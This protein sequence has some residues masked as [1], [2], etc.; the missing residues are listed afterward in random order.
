MP[1]KPSVI[2]IADGSLVNVSI[3]GLG[4]EIV[5]VGVVIVA[6]VR[7][8]ISLCCVVSRTPAAGEGDGNRDPARPRRWA[9]YKA[10]TAECSDRSQN[11][12]KERGRGQAT[13]DMDILPNRET[14][15]QS[16]SANNLELHEVRWLRHGSEFPV[17]FEYLPC[18][19]WR[20]WETLLPSVQQE[21]LMFCCLFRLRAQELV[22]ALTLEARARS[23]TSAVSK[24]EC[25]Q[26]SLQQG[27]KFPED[28]CKREHS[29]GS[30]EHILR[31]RRTSLLEPG[32]VPE[33]RESLKNRDMKISRRYPTAS[34]SV[35]QLQAGVATRRPEKPKPSGSKKIN[36]S[37]G[38]LFYQTILLRRASISTPVTPI[39]PITPLTL[40]GVGVRPAS[41]TENG[42]SP[43]TH[44]GSGMIRSNMFPSTSMDTDG[45][46]HRNSNSR[47]EKL[48]HTF[49]TNSFP[50]ATLRP[51]ELRAKSGSL[52]YVPRA[53]TF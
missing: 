10:P 26:P 9:S 33:K 8:I 29:Q 13:G 12:R 21:Y 31:H 49:S 42:V 53:P 24:R 47:A 20:G 45:Y 32:A 34:T 2:P 27:L 46:P 40:P 36:V 38:A 48:T 43:R 37:S 41:A 35:P 44:L 7:I 4:Q 14:D 17:V 15:R 28:H 50:Q 5:F 51:A 22:R 1:G 25:P 23:C 6:F 39:T 18:A 3:C 11:R 30:N 16:D 52:F 19:L